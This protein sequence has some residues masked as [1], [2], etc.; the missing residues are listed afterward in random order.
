V[1]AEYGSVRLT[2]NF[3]IALFPE[4]TAIIMAVLSMLIP[5]AREH[6]KNV[7]LQAIPL[8]ITVVQSG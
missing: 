2:L 1:E 3:L 8:P 5:I 7:H 6:S 4:I